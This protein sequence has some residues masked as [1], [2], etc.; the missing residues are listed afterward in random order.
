M[1]VKQQIVGGYEVGALLGSGTVGEVYHAR[2]CESGIPAVL[3]FLHEQ[4]A[5]EPDAQ[6]RFVREVAIAEKLDHPNIVRHYDCGLHDDQYF[7]AMEFVDCGTLKDMLRQRRT[8]PW[9]EAAECAI[10][11][12]AAL[13]HAHDRGIIHR[14]L[15]PANL[16]VSTE[17]QVKVG[18]F[19]LARDVNK[20]RLTLEG[21]TVGTCRYMAP[22]QITGD[23]ELTGAAD[24]YAL[25]CILYRAIVGEPPFDGESIIDIFEA[26]LYSEPRPPAILA[27]DCPE[28]LSDLIMRL[29]EKDP[30]DRP[31]SAAQV[32]AALEDIVGG[33]RTKLIPPR[34][35]E[36][37]IEIGEAQVSEADPTLPYSNTSVTAITPVTSSAAAKTKRRWL[38]AVAVIALAAG[39]VFAAWQLLM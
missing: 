35:I 4:T 32:Q 34:R 36:P 6:R 12:C 30:R 9:R 1:V 29:L 37:S 7:F 19:G 23:A 38:V 20:S 33:R 17:G 3:K 2:H 31:A 28:D 8:L 14:D 16:F 10:Q 11:I 27:D 25:G 21:Q 18:D 39:L 26:H 15:K 13:Q 5:R 24:L 22:E